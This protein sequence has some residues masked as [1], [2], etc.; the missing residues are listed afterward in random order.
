M[1]L[2]KLSK[3]SKTIYDLLSTYYPQWIPLMN[4]MPS[5]KEAFEVEIPAPPHIRVPLIIDTDEERLSVFFDDHHQH[6]VWQ[7]VPYIETFYEAKEMIDAIL[8]GTYLSASFIR[9]G[10]WS[11]SASL[12]ITELDEFKKEYPFYNRIVSWK[13]AYLL[14]DNQSIL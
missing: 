5:N 14:E 4:N 13:Q 6:F 7:D 2:E 3:F 9:N 10:K 12:N 1:E 8:D 11:G